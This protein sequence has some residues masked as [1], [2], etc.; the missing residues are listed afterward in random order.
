MNS[1]KNLKKLMSIADAID[2]LLNV[3]EEPLI[4]LSEIRRIIAKLREHHPYPE[5][6]FV[7]EGAEARIGYNCC[8]KEF[9]DWLRAWQE[10]ES[11]FNK[12]SERGK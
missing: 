1:R 8:I 9:E 3:P 12:E 7:R 6:I 2:G 11:E 10:Q 4:P 5:K